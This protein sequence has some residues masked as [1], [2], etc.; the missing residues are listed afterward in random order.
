MGVSVAHRQPDCSSS[1][2]LMPN[3]ES[4]LRHSGYYGNGA[5]KVGAGGSTT[6][7]S[8]S[9]VTGPPRSRP[10]KCTRPT[11]GFPRAVQPQ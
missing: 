4:F 9:G 10:R 7:V 6:V 11:S 5:K 3:D 8:Q 2:S 1:V